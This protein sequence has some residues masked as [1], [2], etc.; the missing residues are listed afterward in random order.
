MDKDIK[1]N[2][3]VVA[4]SKYNETSDKSLIEAFSLDELL[5]TKALRAG[6]RTSNYY[7]LIEDR[8]DELKKIKDSKSNLKDQIKLLTLGALLGIAGT[9]LSLYFWSL[10]NNQ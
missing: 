5:E 6:Q 2:K 8:I 1:A 10:I 3:V 9:L 7:Y 4:F